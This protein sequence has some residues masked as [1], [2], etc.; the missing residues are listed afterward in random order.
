VFAPFRPSSSIEDLQHETLRML[1]TIDVKMLII[2]EIH[3]VLAGPLLKYMG[4]ERQIPLVAAGTHDAFNAIQIDPQLA[5]RFEPALLPRWSM[6]EG[7]W[8]GWALTHTPAAATSRSSRSNSVRSTPSTIGLTHT[9]TPS[10]V[11]NC[12]RT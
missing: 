6:N 1:E 4:N 12:A 3:N 8:S 2:D 10:Q 7:S 9:R 11:N 5:N